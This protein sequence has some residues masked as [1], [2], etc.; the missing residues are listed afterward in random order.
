M[1]E[2]L[3]I[4]ADIVASILN[5]LRPIVSPMGSLMVNWMDVVLKFF[6]FGN[7]MPYI[8]A[9]IIIILVA[10]IVNI[11]WPG[12]RPP[13]FLDKI[14]KKLKKAEKAVEE[15]EAKAEEEAEE[16]K[17]EVEETVEEVEAETEEEAEEMK[18]E[19]EE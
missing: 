13:I 12:D 11:L 2:F 10:A 6:P 1:S 4:L 19:V 3:Q 8:T 7:L 5:F 18:A 15:V 17:A 14:K 9:F 16:I